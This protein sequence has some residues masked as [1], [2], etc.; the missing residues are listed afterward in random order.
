MADLKSIVESATD[1]NPIVQ[2]INVNGGL[3]SDK[4]RAE[5][6]KD[7]YAFFRAAYKNLNLDIN[8]IFKMY[9]FLD[10][11]HYYITDSGSP[12]SVDL[13]KAIASVI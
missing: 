7:N 3:W 6:R 5:L 8:D 4:V 9:L 10:L 11:A 13:E 2:W 12:T 1:D